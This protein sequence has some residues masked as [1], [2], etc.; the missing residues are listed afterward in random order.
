[1]SK[2]ML[3]TLKELTRKDP[4]NPLGRY[5]LANEYL[6]LG[7][8]EQAISEISAYLKLKED[9]G[10]AYRILGESLLKLGRKDEARDAF[11]RG[12]EVAERH[13]HMDMALEFEE[14]LESLN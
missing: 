8:Y 10:A 12:M 4:N 6:K 14:T 9:E 2:S 11:R 3:E 1:M 13:G 7:M 5:G